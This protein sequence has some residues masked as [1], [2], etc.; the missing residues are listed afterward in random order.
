MPSD[1]EVGGEA[2]VFGV[3]F[4]LGVS[5]F[6]EGEGEG[7]VCGDVSG[8]VIAEPLSGGGGGGAEEG[9]G[10]RAGV[11]GE[12]KFGPVGVCDGEELD[13]VGLVIGVEEEGGAEDGAGAGDG[14]FEVGDT[15]EGLVGLFELEFSESSEGGVG[16]DDF[17]EGVIGDGEV[18]GGVGGWGGDGELEG[19]D[20]GGA[21]VIGGEDAV[22]AGAV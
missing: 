4:S 1:T 21:V 20:G 8:E 14:D 11:P 15:A 18:D 3:D 7:A 19:A 2:V 5:G 10:G 6:F 17:D 12:V 13:G 9:S 16:V 22:V